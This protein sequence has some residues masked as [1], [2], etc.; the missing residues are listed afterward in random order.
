MPDPEPLFP[1]GIIDTTIEHIEEMCVANFPGNKMRAYIFQRFLGYIEALRGVNAMFHVWVDGSF[2][3]TKQEPGDI[4]LF[5]WFNADAID[6]LADKDKR[7]LHT[8][9]RDRPFVKAQYSVDIYYGVHGDVN[10]RMYWRGCYGYTRETEQ[11]KG[12]PQIV[13]GRRD[14]P[15]SVA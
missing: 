6:S 14:E 11:P 12:I 15:D 8:L 1:P 9:L 7:V 3:T 13:V 4:D 5:I 2:V 10:A